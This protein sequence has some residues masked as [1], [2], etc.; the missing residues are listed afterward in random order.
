MKNK[1]LLLIILNL[2]LFTNCKENKENK[3]STNT[4][5]EIQTSFTNKEYTEI[6]QQDNIFKLSCATKSNNIKLTDKTLYLEIVEPINYEIEKIDNVSQNEIKI[7]LKNETFYYLVKTVDENKKISYWQNYDSNTNKID[8]DFSFY[9]IEKTNLSNANLE[10]EN[11]N[12]DDNDYKLLNDSKTKIDGFELVFNKETD[13]N[14]DGIKDKIFVLKNKLDF[15]PENI[16]TQK[17][18]IILFLSD[19]NNFKK[20]I[21]TSIFPNSLNDLFDTIEINKNTIKIKLFNEV[22]N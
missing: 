11:C 10:K 9:A 22:P 8:T 16:E 15:N 17:S 2:F 7:F 12:N 6:V 21:N 3:N 5:T 14:S 4:T 20:L 19:K 13:L 1:T 18:K